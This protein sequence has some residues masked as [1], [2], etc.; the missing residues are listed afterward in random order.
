MVNSLIFMVGQGRI[1]LP[2]LGFSACFI[3]NLHKTISNNIKETLKVFL[4]WF[5]VSRSVFYGYGHNLVTRFLIEIL[6]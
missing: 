3:N 4:C 6:N 2:T 5:I 1:E